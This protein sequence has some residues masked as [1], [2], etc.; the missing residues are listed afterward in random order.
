MKK[1]IKQNRRSK[2]QKVK[3]VKKVK[4]NTRK[5]Q[6]K[7]SQTRKRYQKV[8]GGSSFPFDGLGLIPEQMMHGVRS[9]LQPINDQIGGLSVDPNPTNQFLENQASSSSYVESKLAS[10]S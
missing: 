1:R 10:L 2:S 5:Q 4:R 3:R 7:R 6:R 9:F 8:K